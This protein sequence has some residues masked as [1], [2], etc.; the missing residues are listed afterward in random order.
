MTLSSIIGLNKSYWDLKKLLSAVS[1]KKEVGRYALDLIAFQQDKLTK[2]K[3]SYEPYEED[4]LDSLEYGKEVV[5][6]AY[7]VQVVQDANISKFEKSLDNT[8]QYLVEEKE[9]ELLND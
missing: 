4:F 2:I 8:I 9:G 5:V 3:S 7:E 1:D 6:A